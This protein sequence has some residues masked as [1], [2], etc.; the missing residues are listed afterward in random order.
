MP[1]ELLLPP[2]GS[3]TPLGRLTVAKLL[4]VPVAE[5]SMATASWKPP[6]PFGPEAGRRR[7]VFEAES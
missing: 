7:T 2:M 5:A 6:V 1:V 4:K 3:V